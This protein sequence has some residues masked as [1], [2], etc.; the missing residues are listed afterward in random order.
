MPVGGTDLDM[1]FMMRGRSSVHRQGHSPA[2]YGMPDFD[3]PFGKVLKLR[4]RREARYDISLREGRAVQASAPEGLTLRDSN[5]HFR[6]SSPRRAHDAGSASSHAQ[7][8]HRSG[9]K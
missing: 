5:Q 4:L 9:L 6:K 8:F 2:G 1:F 7:D 3:L